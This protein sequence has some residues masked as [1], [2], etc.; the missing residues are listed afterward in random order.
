MA[1]RLALTVRVRVR[2]SLTLTLTLTLTLIRSRLAQAIFEF[3]I[4]AHW[5][6]MHTLWYVY[7]VDDDT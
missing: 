2:V 7:Y 1:R 3:S 5:E 6:D 4:R